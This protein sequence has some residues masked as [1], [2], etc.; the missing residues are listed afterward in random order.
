MAN[1]HLGDTRST[2]HSASTYT[3]SSAIVLGQPVVFLLGRMHPPW[4]SLV[5]NYVSWKRFMP[6]TRWVRFLRP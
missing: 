1:P 4:L 6:W 3:L 2:P 5:W